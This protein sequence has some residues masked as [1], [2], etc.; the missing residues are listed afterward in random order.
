MHT[1]RLNTMENYKK[2]AQKVVA[3]AVAYESF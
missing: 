2:P 3:V 1:K